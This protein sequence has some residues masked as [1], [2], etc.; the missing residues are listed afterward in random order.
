MFIILKVIHSLQSIEN[1]L[2]ECC[3]MQTTSVHILAPK[4]IRY[5]TLDK[6]LNLSGPQF[7]QLLVMAIIIMASTS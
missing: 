6:L 5:L 2:H 3:F 4:P 7:P 1:C